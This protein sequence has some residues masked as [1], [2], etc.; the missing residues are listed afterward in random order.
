MKVKKIG[1]DKASVS[2]LKTEYLSRPHARQNT[3]D[4]R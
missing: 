1:G 4:W 2:F 3:E